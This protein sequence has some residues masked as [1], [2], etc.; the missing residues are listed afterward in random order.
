M[1]FVYVHCY[2]VQGLSTDYMIY[3]LNID[4][5]GQAAQDMKRS[6]LTRSFLTPTTEPTINDYTYCTVMASCTSSESTTA[7]ASADPVK[8]LR[9]VLS[10]F[11]ADGRF[12]VSTEESKV[13]LDLSD[14]E[15]C[16]TF[17]GAPRRCLSPV[18]LAN[19]Y[20]SNSHRPI[21]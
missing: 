3:S 12:T 1:P 14:T 13:C 15:I 6:L 16:K 7:T 5:R 18:K 20:P 11:L 19:T 4:S 9:M 2:V 17:C 10:G 21:F 8:L